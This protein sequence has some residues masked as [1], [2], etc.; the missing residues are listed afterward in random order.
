[1]TFKEQ[2]DQTRMMVENK[3]VTYLDPFKYTKQRKIHEAMCYS[4]MSGG[5]RFR[6]VIFLQTIAFFGDYPAEFIDC[7]CALEYIHTYSLIHDDLPAMDNDDYRRGKLTN[8]KVYGEDMAIL[9][10]DALLNSAF[11]ILIQKVL[12]NPTFHVIEGVN[13]I[14][15][16][17]GVGGM[18]GG[19][20]VDLESED[21]D[22]DIRTLQFIHE[23]K[24]AALIEASILSAAL[25]CNAK[26]SEFRALEDYAKNLG[27]AFQ[28]SDDILDEV[29][30]FEEL[31]KPIGSDKQN[32][33]ST[34]VS[35]YG[36][37]ES[38]SQLKDAVDKAIHSL[39]IFDSK[40][41]NKEF[42]VNIA[43]YMLERH[44]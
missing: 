21:H 18:I 35:H 31:G 11:E 14:A 22:V 43:N 6:P 29:G 9:A 8:H 15:Q 24:T 2:Y 4:L 37:E 27:L 17:A 16:K 13:L 5:K 10:G 34:F 41:F 42:F 32:H 28:I 19:Q 3:L 39:E 20:V 7:A 1:M 44:S 40:E 12:H 33:K 36:L 25:M 38:K 30:T 23:H 26:K